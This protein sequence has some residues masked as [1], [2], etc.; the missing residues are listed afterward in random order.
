[1]KGSSS[2]IGDALLEV[3]P[4]EFAKMTSEEHR[5]RYRLAVVSV[6][7][8]ATKLVM[9]AWSHE[10]DAWVGDGLILVLHQV[11]S[12]QVEII[13]PSTKN[14]HDAQGELPQSSH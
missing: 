5:D 6:Q 11:M 13:G 8:T 2:K 10:A 3:T 4:N 7:G 12:A 14:G 1:M 9:F